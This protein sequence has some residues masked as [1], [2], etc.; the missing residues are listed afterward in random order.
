[1]LSQRSFLTWLFII[2][3]KSTLDDTLDV[4]PCHGIGGMVGMLMTGLFATKAVNSGGADGLIPSGNI[5]FF[6][7]Q[8]KGMAIVVAY[9]FTVS[10]LIFKLINLI[11]P[12]R[13]SSEEEELGLDATQHNEKYLQGTLLV[14][15]STN[16]KATIVEE[17]ALIEE[18]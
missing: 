8:L 11:Q 15:S 17:K 10:F 9:S 6:L 14:T 12:L 18:A 2:N 7:I 1:V 3:Q 5:D 16:G 13:V 4:F